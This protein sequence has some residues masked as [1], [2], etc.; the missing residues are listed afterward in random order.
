MTEE[1]SADTFGSHVDQPHIP[2]PNAW[3]RGPVDI[4]SL[5]LSGLFLLALFYTLYLARA[6]F[7][8]IVLALMLHFLLRPVVSGLKTLRF[9]EP[10]GAAVVIGAFAGVVTIGAYWL[11]GPASLWIAQIP[12]NLRQ[13]EWKLR[14][15]KRSVEKV[16]KATEQV[17]Q[18]TKVGEKTTP[19]VV[20]VEVQQSWIVDSM[21]NVTLSV[22]AGAVVMIILLYFLLA[23]G[24]L[25]LLK[26]V[27]VLPRLQDKKTAVT[28]VQHVQTDVSRYLSTVT[29]INGCLAAVVSLAMFL[30]DMPNPILWG[31]MAGALNFI[32]YLGAITSTV[33]LSLV[34]L[35]SFYDVWQALRVPLIFI[36][37]TSIEGLLI[38]P[39]I[40][41]RR[42]TLNPVVIFIWLTFWGWMW[43]APGALLAVPML[44]TFKILCDHLPPLSPIGEFL[45]H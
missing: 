45:G 9:P 34:A 37:L 19:E 22:V 10:L 13:I 41:G 33:V 40:V 31:V 15:F 25:F 20:K 42:L 4:R 17:E 44:A 35:L 3:L 26:L 23:S 32:P 36:G 38:T 18:I 1:T 39:L 5:A 6:I 24:D 8:P 28:I 12:Q 2:H 7:L 43:G 16:S 21:L 14:D 11:S 29:L 27:R 30:L